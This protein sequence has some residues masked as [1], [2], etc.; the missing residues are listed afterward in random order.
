MPRSAC[1]ESQNSVGEDPRKTREMH[2]KTIQLVTVLVK[3]ARL[4]EIRV[5]RGKSESYSEN[6]T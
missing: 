3:V 2:K 5:V 4:R 6:S 1:G